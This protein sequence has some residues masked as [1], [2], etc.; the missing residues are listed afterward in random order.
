VWLGKIPSDSIGL[1]SYPIDLH[2]VDATDHEAFAPI[3][4]VYGIP[5]GAMVPR[6]IDNLVLASPAISA[7]HLASGSARVI[8]TTI[9]EGEAAGVACA[10]ADRSGI[11]IAQLAESVSDVALLRH[12]LTKDGAIVGSPSTGDAERVATAPVGTKS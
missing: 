4:H 3:R 2:P 5:L 8:P 12:D 1:S 10:D 6:G 7:S 11:D 9:E